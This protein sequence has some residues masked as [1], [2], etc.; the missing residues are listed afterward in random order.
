MNETR[1]SFKV[2]TAPRCRQ[3]SCHLQALISE[4]FGG[5]LP[6]QPSAESH[7]R[8][9]TYYPTFDIL[10][11]LAEVVSKINTS[12][13]SRVLVS[14]FYRLHM[15]ILAAEKENFWN[16]LQKNPAE[17]KHASFVIKFMF[18][19]GRHEVLPVLY[20]VCSILT[21]IPATSC[22]SE[23]SFS[24]WLVRPWITCIVCHAN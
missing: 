10:C 11:A 20:K 12:P 2:A 3:P 16:F 13:K 8:V 9:T 22:S 7:C 18:Q 23:R 4:Q 24:Y 15:E 14:S 17:I 6:S 1:F 5:E 19:N 21:T